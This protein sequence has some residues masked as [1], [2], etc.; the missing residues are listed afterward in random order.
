MDDKGEGGDAKSSQDEIWVLHNVA[1]TLST[2]AS[3]PEL[4]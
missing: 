3:G 4:A 1:V 2:M